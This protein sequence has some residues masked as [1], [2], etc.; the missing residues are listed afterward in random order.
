MDEEEAPDETLKSKRSRLLK[1]LTNSTD[2][3]SIYNSS[4]LQELEDDDCTN[5]ELHGGALPPPKATLK[6]VMAL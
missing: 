2:H 1:P 4:C 3:V 5:P 6:S